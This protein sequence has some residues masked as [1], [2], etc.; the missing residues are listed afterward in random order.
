MSVSFFSSASPQAKVVEADTG[1]TKRK[2]RFAGHSTA[3]HACEPHF[4][5]DG[6]FLSSGDA[7]GNLVIWDWKTSRI[8][9]RIKV[10]QKPLISHAWLPHETSKIVTSSWD[11]TIRL[12]D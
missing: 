7:Q 8:S 10:H 11:G 2:K 9:T 6:R 3:G 5:P 1:L 12:L 4:S